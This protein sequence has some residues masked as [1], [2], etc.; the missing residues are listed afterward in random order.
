MH[1]PT[2]KLPKRGTLAELVKAL[3]EALRSDYPNHADDIC[4]WVK[5]ELKAPRS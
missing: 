1:C 5:A 3:A 2:I 4:D